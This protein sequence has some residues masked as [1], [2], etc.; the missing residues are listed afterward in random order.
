MKNNDELTPTELS[1]RRRRL[2]AAKNLLKECDA[3]YT[4]NHA[5]I[6]AILREI[7]DVDNA[8][9]QSVTS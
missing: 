5:V 4:E 9:K 7:E 1:N 6:K 3:P 2:V 8:I